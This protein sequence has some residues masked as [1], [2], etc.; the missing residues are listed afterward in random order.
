MNQLA[1]C[2]LQGPQRHGTAALVVAAQLW[3]GMLIDLLP[4][5]IYSSGTG[6]ERGRPR[7]LGL[8]SEE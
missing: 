6:P 7:L 1:T 8:S 4:I 2:M 3:L 5:S